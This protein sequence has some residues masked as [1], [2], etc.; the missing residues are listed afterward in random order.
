MGPAQAPGQMAP[1]VPG[2]MGGWLL[3][4]WLIANRLLAGSWLVA[5][6]LLPGSFLAACWQIEDWFLAGSRLVPCWLLVISWLG[7]T[8]LTFFDDF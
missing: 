2:P 7:S 8:L 5:G 3:A 1:W 4:C 6:L